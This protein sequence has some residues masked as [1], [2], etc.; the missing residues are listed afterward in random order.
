MLGYF[1]N[2]ATSFPKPESVADRIKEYLCE[3]GGPYGRSFYPNALTVAGVVEGARDII[4]GKLGVHDAENISFCNNATFG[5]NTV[6]HG[7][8]FR[9]AEVV[10]S[11]MEHNAV[12]RPLMHLKNQLNLT[13][14]YIPSERDGLINLDKIEDILTRKTALVI[15]NHQSNVNGVIQPVDKLKR[16]TGAVPVLLDLA[17]SLGEIDINLDNWDIDF[18]AFTGH[19]S[20]LG[21]TGTGGL[22]IENSTT[23]EPL[24]IG[25]TGSKSE[26]FDYP[27]FLPDKFEAG[28]P[29]IAGIFGLYGA[30]E[31]K[32]TP[33]H[34][35]DDFIS[36]IDQVGKLKGYKVYRADSVENQG[37]VFSIN[38][39]KMSCSELCR[40]LSVKY[41]LYTRAGLHC[42]PLAHQTLRTF[43]E[44]TMRISPSVYH[45]VKDFEYFI[46]ALTEIDKS[47]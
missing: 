5:I 19:K 14:K 44:G 27:E 41:K 39:R 43:P 31:N 1:D 9:G 36:F 4:A 12:M 15:V 24:I 23:L 13:V 33:K 22:Y 42:A 2:A 8:L 30:L 25:G 34:S 29:N 40:I 18:A 17:Q 38:S 21:P 45:T 35:R 46:S 16:I 10:V 3:I 6:L 7:L 47:E 26:S 11:C 37:K 28:T 20:L 32:I